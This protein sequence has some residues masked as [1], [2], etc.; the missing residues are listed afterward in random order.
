MAVII[1]FLILEY[2]S[3]VHCEFKRDNKAFL[4]AVHISLISVILRL[5]FQ[6]ESYHS[7]SLSLLKSIRSVSFIERKT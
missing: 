5:T 2:L 7:Q 4:H 3:K 6:S 1:G